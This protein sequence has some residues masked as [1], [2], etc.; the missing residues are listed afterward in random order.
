MNQLTSDRAVRRSGGVAAAFLAATIGLYAW[1]AAAAL[2]LDEAVT[3]AQRNDPWIL[4]SEYRQDSL[5]A[6]A[7]AAGTLPDP[8]VDLSFANMPTDTFD[9]DQEAM[10]QFKVG[11]AQA[12]PRG[13]TRALSQRR[14]AMLG[15]QF[16]YQRDDRRARLAVAA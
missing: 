1:P 5:A 9:F 6:Q 3:I 13:D 10:T 7:V 12:F 2:S 16:P 11:I 15:E 4:S 8:M 14:L